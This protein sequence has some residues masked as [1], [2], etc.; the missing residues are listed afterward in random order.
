M[1][2]IK[3]NEE[4]QY[5]VHPTHHHVR[6]EDKD[7]LKTNCEYLNLGHAFTPTALR[8]KKLR[9]VVEVVE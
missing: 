7:I 3:Q 9:L 2:T 1:T 4:G 5:T 8:G 6:S